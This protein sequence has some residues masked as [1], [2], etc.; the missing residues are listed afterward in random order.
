MRWKQTEYTG[1][2][3]ALHATAEIARP[4]RLSALQDAVADSPAPA[5]GQL[6]SYGDAALN[7]GGRTIDMTRLDRIL[8]FDAASGVVEVEA[9]AL[10]GDLGRIFAAQGWI[11][12]VMPGTGFATVGGCIANDVHGKNH[13]VVGS[14][15]SMSP[16]LPFSAAAVR[17]WSHRTR[18]RIF[19][20]R[21]LAAWARQGSSRP[22]RSS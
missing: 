20:R 18:R 11:P 21:R 22:P 6:R 9:G 4:E 13:H 14:S 7:D 16:R 8:G 15:A 17:A 10:I 19:S 1:W 2:G 12:P 3:R 5:I